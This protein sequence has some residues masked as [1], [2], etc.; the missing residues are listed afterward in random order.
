[1]IPSDGVTDAL[2]ALHLVS[3]PTGAVSL[4]TVIGDV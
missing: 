1:M 4:L 3:P 2:L